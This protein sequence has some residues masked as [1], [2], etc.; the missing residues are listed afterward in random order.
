MMTGG[1]LDPNRAPA[2]ASDPFPFTSEGGLQRT[3]SAHL[4]ENSD[5]R[6]LLRP[7]DLP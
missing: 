3:R 6:G 1:K 2:K 5:V 4:A 7:T